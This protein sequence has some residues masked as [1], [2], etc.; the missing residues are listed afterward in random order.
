MASNLEFFH[1]Q[2]RGKTSMF[3][4]AEGDAQRTVNPI[5]LRG[6]ERLIFLLIFSQI[7]LINL[8]FFRQT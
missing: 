8:H 2:T 6:D 7:N 3:Y 5:T 4:P 1:P